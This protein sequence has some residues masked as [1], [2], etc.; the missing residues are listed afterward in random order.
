MPAKSR[1]P[2]LETSP[3]ALPRS[4]QVAEQ[5]R[6]DILSGRLAPGVRLTEA[7]LSK[8]FGVGR[9]PVR[10]AVQ[11]LTQQ[12]LLVTR[13]NCGA[14]VAPEAPEG[15]RGLIVPIRRSIELYAL[16]LVFEDLND[17]DFRRW[18]EIVRK[19]KVACQ[20]QDSYTLAELDLAFHRTLLERAEQT[21]LLVIWDTL[22]SRIRSHFRRAQRR[23]ATLMDVYE[24][25]RAIVESYRKGNLRDAT[26]MLR[27]NIV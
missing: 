7:E 23:I 8:R 16:E 12:R 11:Q 2:T 20:E 5:L 27:D 6:G 13:P 22:V 17:D 19:M 18:D 24:E 1:L 25:H 3:A 10:E 15:L 14:V 9:G 4:M 21:D 26:K